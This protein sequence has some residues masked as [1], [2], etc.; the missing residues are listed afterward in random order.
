MVF[1]LLLLFFVDTVFV[2]GVVVIALLHFFVVVVAVVGVGIDCDVEQ[3]R[4]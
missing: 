2:V 3:Y 4:I 1:V